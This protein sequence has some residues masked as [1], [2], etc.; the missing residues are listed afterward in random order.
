[1]A[2]YKIV[3][4]I[5]TAAERNLHDFVQRAKEAAE[6]AAVMIDSIQTNS[7]IEEKELQHGKGCPCFMCLKH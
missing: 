6:E 7:I 4:E 3:M 1:M 2:K 5:D